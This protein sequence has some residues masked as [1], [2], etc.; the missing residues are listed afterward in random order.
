M[1]RGFSPGFNRDVRRAQ[2]LPDLIR[3]VVSSEPSLAEHGDGMRFETFAL[4]VAM[5]CDVAMITGMRAVAGFRFR[6][7]ST[8]VPSMSG[9]RRSRKMTSG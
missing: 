2:R 3:A 7:A 4:T 8:S 5:I 6:R 1:G 9:I